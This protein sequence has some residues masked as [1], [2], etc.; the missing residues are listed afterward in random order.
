MMLQSCKAIQK[1]EDESWAN[2]SCE[3][4]MKQPTWNNLPGNYDDCILPLLAISK[5]EIP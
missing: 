4:N 1:N 5:K 3:M 2:L